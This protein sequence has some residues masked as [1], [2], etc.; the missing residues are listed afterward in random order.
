[1][2]LPNQTNADAPC[3]TSDLQLMV[4]QFKFTRSLRSVEPLKSDV[5][6]EVSPGPECVTDE[7]IR[8]PPCSSFTPH[9][10]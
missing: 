7:Q 9:G 2:M 1:M 3:T 6:A 8:S 4:E 10:I 5:I